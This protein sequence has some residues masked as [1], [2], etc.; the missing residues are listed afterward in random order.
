MTRCEGRFRVDCLGSLLV[1][2]K[3]SILEPSSQYLS[4]PETKAF[5]P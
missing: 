2:P 5:S 3:S 4:L 1:D